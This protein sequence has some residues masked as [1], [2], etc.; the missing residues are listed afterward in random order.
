MHPM[1][2]ERFEVRVT[3]DPAKATSPPRPELRSP[4]TALSLMPDDVRVVLQLDGLAEREHHRRRAKMGVTAGRA[5]SGLSILTQ[6]VLRL[7][8]RHATAGHGTA[9]IL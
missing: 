3:F 1:R 9:D 7:T 6:G 5:R 8:N 2:D 4:V